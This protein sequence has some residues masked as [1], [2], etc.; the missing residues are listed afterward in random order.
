MR[1]EIHNRPRAT[2]VIDYSGLRYGQITPTDI[3]GLLEFGNN[4]FIFIE[5][6]HREAPMPHGQELALTRVVDNMK[7]VPAY[8]I[9]ARHKE[10][11]AARDI[12]AADGCDVSAVYYKGTW[13][14]YKEEARIPLGEAI[15]LLRK[16]W[17]A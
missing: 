1:G 6:K 10:D 12:N 17:L 5:I 16:L 3:D 14:K 15:E 13:K 11:D 7:D 8:L 2:Q 4:L 9:L